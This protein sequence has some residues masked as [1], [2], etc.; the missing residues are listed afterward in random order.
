M[1]LQVHLCNTTRDP[2]TVAAVPEGMKGA[3]NDAH[4]QEKGSVSD[5]KNTPEIL[6]GYYLETY[7]DKRPCAVRNVCRVDRGGGIY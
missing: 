6:G 3:E 4:V 7:E 1:L 5:L 2:E